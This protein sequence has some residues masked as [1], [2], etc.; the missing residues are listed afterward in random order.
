[1]KQIFTIRPEVVFRALVLLKEN[2]RFYA[3][4]EISEELLN[5]YRDDPDVIV[6][7]IVVVD[8]SK[9]GQCQGFFK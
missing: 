7:Q 6:N 9:D 4:V 2:N 3:D 1:M 8:T 5:R